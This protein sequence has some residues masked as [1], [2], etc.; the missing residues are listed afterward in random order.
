MGL[1]SRIF[2]FWLLLFHLNSLVQSLCHD[3][4]CFALWQFKESLVINEQASVDPSAYP[5]VNSWKLEGENGDCCSW[6]GVKCHEVTGDVIGLNLTSSYLYGSINSSS[7]LFCLVNLEWFSLADNDF[8]GSKIPSGI[9]NFSKLSHLDL[10]ATNFSGQIPSEILEL[11]KLED[12]FLWQNTH[13]ELQKP[14]LKSLIEKLTNLKTLYLSQVNISSSI[15]YILTNQSSLTELSLR[16]CRLQGEFPTKIFQLPNLQFLSVR[17]NPDLIGYLP[18]FDASSPLQDLRLGGTSFTGEIPNSIGKL[19]S[20][21]LLDIHDCNFLGTIPSSLGN[22]AKI[23]FL[24]LSQNKF[25]GKLP[26]LLGN[27][28]SLEELSVSNNNFSMQNALSLSWI[29]RHIRLTYLGI[30]KINLVGEIPSWLMNL[31]QLQFLHMGYNQLTGPIPNWLMNHNK[32]SDLFLQS[33][34]LTGCIPSHTRNL[35]KLT[36]LGLSLNQL[37]GPIPASISELENLQVLDLQWNNLSGIVD[38]HMFLYKLN[39]LEVLVLSSNSLSLITKTNIHLEVKQLWFLGLASCNLKEFPNILHNLDKLQILD[40]SSN[41]I[42]GQIPEWFLNQSVHSLLCLNLS[43][44]LLTGFQYHPDFLPW[45]RLSWIDLRYNKFQG[46]LQI[47]PPSTTLYLVSHN[48]LN[49]EIPPLICNLSRLGVLDLSYN[50]FSGRLPQCLDNLNYTLS[51]LNLRS[52]KFCGSIPSTLLSGTNLKWID[53]SHNELQRRIPRSLANCRMLEFLDLGNNQ[54]SD[55]FPSW[56]GTLPELKVLILQANRLWGVIRD[57][58]TN[59]AFP[60][61]RIINLSGNRF[62]GNLPSKYFQSWNAMRVENASGLA[63]MQEE[64]NIELL[65]GFDERIAL[66]Q[67]PYVYSVE[68]NTK[69]IELV[70]GKIS[71]LLTAIIFSSNRFQGEI[72]ESIANLRGL[73][74]LRLSN[75]YLSGPIPSSLGKLVA[76]ESLDLSNNRLSGQIP[77]ELAEITFLEIFNVSNNHLTGPIPQGKQFATF[78]NDSYNG[79]PGLCGKPLSKQCESFQPSQGHDSDLHQPLFEIYREIILIGY[80]SGL[81]VG[82]VLGNTFGRRSHG[83]L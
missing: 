21:S 63:Y 73:H 46:P 77:P 49:S 16:E 34:Q 17:Y 13:M 18:E 53:L 72:P 15:P 62:T 51:M 32:L 12:L 81:I 65:T 30:S 68:I 35:T 1:S 42:A 36:G 58:E 37:E 55:V 22:L 38:L 66:F 41:K 25:S 27:L 60:K 71:N 70:Y 79:N 59:F 82:V 83:R 47:P 6:D 7:C 3:N 28:T 23:S 33:N 54:I 4:E 78:E 40:L 45:T 19:K 9:I 74:F 52:N 50:K 57:P 44:N 20:L 39:F 11:S 80:A 5:K 61:L 48:N 29:S 56:L 69:G 31:T 26:P 76:L 64:F 8:N 2:S 75:N 10:T 43:H 14:S 67:F 24:Y